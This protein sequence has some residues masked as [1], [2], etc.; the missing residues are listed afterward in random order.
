LGLIVL[1]GRT[2]SA[3]AQIDSESVA[4]ELD[5]EKSVARTAVSGLVVVGT[6]RRFS[7]CQNADIKSFGTIRLH[8][9]RNVLSIIPVH[10]YAVTYLGG[11]PLL[12]GCA[13]LKGGGLTIEVQIKG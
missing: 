10:H 11:E 4:P 13:V 2:V 7:I 6:E 12:V 3:K 5:Q 8:K 1:L 9:G